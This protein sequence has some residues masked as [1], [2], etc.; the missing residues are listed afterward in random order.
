MTT[1][2]KL[3]STIVQT[4]A[5]YKDEISNKFGASGSG[6]DLCG[7]REYSVSAA[8][9]GFLVVKTSPTLQLEIET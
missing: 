4:F 1:S 9:T 8:C 7:P 2:V 6:I 5:E 3:G